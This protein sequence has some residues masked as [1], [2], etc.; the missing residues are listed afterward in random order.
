MD[1]GE[2]EVLVPAAAGGSSSSNVAPVPTLFSSCFVRSVVRD[3]VEEEVQEEEDSLTLDELADTQPA[4]SQVEEAHR[5]ALAEMQPANSQIAEENR[6]EWARDAMAAGSGPRAE[7]T[8]HEWTRK[9][10][11]SRKAAKVVRCSMCSAIRGMG[12]LLLEVLLL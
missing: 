6:E 7:C 9:G 11:N 2:G 12:H 3:R 1:G 5:D 10:N 8:Q 4:N